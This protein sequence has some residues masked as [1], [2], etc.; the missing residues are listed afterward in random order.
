MAALEQKDTAIPKLLK[1]MEMLRND[2]S[3]EV[4]AQYISQFLLVALH[5]GMTFRELAK[6]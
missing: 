6:D 5:E 1:V 2:I 3:K 4:P